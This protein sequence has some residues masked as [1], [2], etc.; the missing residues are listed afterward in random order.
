MAEGLT[1]SNRLLQSVPQPFRKL[2]SLILI[3]LSELA[4][5]I[6]DGKARLAEAEALEPSH[7]VAAQSANHLQKAESVVEKGLLC[8]VGRHV[9]AQ[10]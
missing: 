8:L 10:A 2:F 1:R 9:I 5:S 3:P 6:R 4:S 7:L